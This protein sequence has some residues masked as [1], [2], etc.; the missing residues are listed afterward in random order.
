MLNIEMLLCAAFE[1][2]AE[3]NDL[4]K[5]TPNVPCELRFQRNRTQ[6]T[7]LQYQQVLDAPTTG[8]R[9]KGFCSQSRRIEDMAL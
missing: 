3:L 1:Q 2:S 6:P 7:T 4:I 9:H 8:V 5:V